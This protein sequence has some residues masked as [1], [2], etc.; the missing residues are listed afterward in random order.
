LNEEKLTKLTA[1]FE[2]SFLKQYNISPFD[3]LKIVYECACKIN[4]EYVRLMN[5]MWLSESKK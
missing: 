4:N 1:T 5:L 2:Q 3:V